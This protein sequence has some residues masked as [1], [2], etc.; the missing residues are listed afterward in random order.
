M[1]CVSKSKLTILALLALVLASGTAYAQTVGGY[2]L[3]GQQRINATTV[4]NTYKASLKNGGLPIQGATATLNVSPGFQIVEGSL[5]FGPLAAGQ[6]GLSTDT[7]VIRLVSGSAS[8]APRLVWNVVVQP[9]GGGATTTLRVQPISNLRAGNLFGVVVE[10]VDAGG[11]IDPSFT[12]MVAL[13]AAA[14]GGSNFTGGTQT[15]PAVAGVATFVGLTL[16]NA[17]DAYLATAS[18]PGAVNGVSN[19]FNVTF[20]TLTVLPVGNVRAGD[21]FN[22]QVEARDANG[23]LAEN[24]GAG[25]ALSLTNLQSAVLAFGQTAFNAPVVPSFGSGTATFTGLSINNA[26]DGYTFSAQATSSGGLVADAINAAFNVTAHHLTVTTVVANHRA[27]TA[28]NAT[29]EARDGNNAVAEN[30]AGNVNLNGAA[31]GGSNFTGGTQTTPAVAGSATF[32]SL[33]LNN[34]ADAYLA[35]ASAAGPSNGVSNAFNVTFTTLAVLPVSSVRAG[36]P[37]NVQVEARDAN[38]VLAENF[39]AGNALSLTSLQSAV[40]AF[41]QIAFNAPVVPSFGSGTATFTGLSINNA[42]D[43]YTF[44][45]QATSSGGLVTDAINA[46]FNVTA[47]HLTVTTVVANHE[48]GSP[49][50]V[51][52]EARDGNDALAENFAGNVNVNAAAAGGSNFVGGTQTTPAV[53]GAA[54]FA[55]L[56]LNTAADT[57]TITA[58]AIGLISGLSNTF[59]VTGGGGGGGGGAE[60]LELS[61]HQ[62]AIGAGGTI[63]IAALVLDDL[64][65]PITPS[66]NINYSILVDEGSSGPPPTVLNGQILT[67]AT[68]RG[69]YILH[70]QVDGTSVIDEILFAVTQNAG[71]SAN[72]GKFVALAAA[73]GTIAAKLAELA[74]AFENGDLAAIPGIKTAIQNAAASVPMTGKNAIQRSRPVAPET[75][76]LPSSAQLT[77][78]GFPVTAADTAFGNLLPQIVAKLSQIKQFYDALPTNPATGGTDSVAALNQ[79]NTDLAGLQAQLE[80]LDITPQAIVLHATAINNLIRSTMPLQ[81]NS[82]AGKIGSVLT[83]NAL[84]GLQ[85]TPGEFFDGA[86]PAETVLAVRS[87]DGFYAQQQPAFFGLLGFFAGSSLQMN[88]VN[89]IYGP[90]MAQVSRMIVIMAANAL[91]EEYVNPASLV[92]LITGASQ[93]IHVYNAPGSVIEGY[94]INTDNVASNEVFLIGGGAVAAVEG[95]IDAFNPGN[96]ESFDDIDDYFEGIVDA[97][98]GAGEAYDTAEQ[99]PDAVQFG[100]IFDDGGG[101]SELVY[102]SGFDNVASCSGFF[103]FDFTVIVLYHNKDTGHWASQLVSFDP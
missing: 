60:S 77:S 66:P 35:T 76:F 5:S 72:A 83:A 1:T 84:A 53:A 39:G 55:N 74:A 90:V 81:M 20:T 4:E 21:P 16:N 26:A 70:G 56:V 93:S 68:T 27:G 2:Q 69:G 14:T 38:G 65:D 46:A 57:Y 102:N 41:G 43:G 42:A 23:V 29:V 45:A 96:I 48:V 97:I 11:T 49:F 89:R 99:P 103:C 62:S 30:F 101:C 80:S 33:T 32:A 54:T 64:G 47:H 63:N 67:S 58:S 25:N 19:A 24:F 71:Q 85:S 50:N 59:N 91:L 100:C 6:T 28:F 8:G 36:D 75:G 3:V 12:G 9:V 22:A 87:P 17:A 95:L 88:L 10:A 44:S 78:A 92:T 37:F 73:E 7:F 86:V 15:T 94:G 52:V 13:N 31:T 40:L 51:T 34:A 82:V 61:L 98:E 79:L 18:A